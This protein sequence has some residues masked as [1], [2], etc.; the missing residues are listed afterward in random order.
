MR[1]VSFYS[2]KMNIMAMEHVIAD[3]E[4]AGYRLKAEPLPNPR[5]DYRRATM[6]SVPF[7]YYVNDVLMSESELLDLHARRV[8]LDEI[9][10][11]DRTHV[12]RAGS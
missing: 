10:R 4:R 9:A 8:P 6:T 2:A 12:Y 5:T 7:I 3:L 1:A 11:T